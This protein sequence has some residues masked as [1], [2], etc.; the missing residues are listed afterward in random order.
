MCAVQLQTRGP[1]I[2][3]HL[4]HK[5]LKHKATLKKTHPHNHKSKRKLQ[6]Q[7]LAFSCSFCS[8]FLF[9]ELKLFLYARLS[10]SAGCVSGLACYIA[11][12]GIAITVDFAYRRNFD[13]ARSMDGPAFSTTHYINHCGPFF[14]CRVITGTGAMTSIFLSIALFPVVRIASTCF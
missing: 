12:H 2:N 11:V 8:E 3:V 5:I 9:C 10:H 13:F 7:S 1:L 6:K 4:P 14:I